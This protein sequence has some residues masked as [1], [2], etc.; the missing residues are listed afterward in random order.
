MNI[1]LLCY[2]VSILCSVFAVSGLNINHIFKKNY[3]WEARFFIFI[4]IFGMSYLLANFIYDILT[5]L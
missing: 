3:K 4:I 2:G 5:I 1:K